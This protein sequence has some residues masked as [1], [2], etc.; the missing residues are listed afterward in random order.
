LSALTGNPIEV[1]GDGS[2]IRSWCYISDFCDAMVEMI[3]RPAAVGQDFNI[4]NPANTVTIL[5][6]AQQILQITNSRVPI[7]FCDH[8]FP[9]IEIRVPSLTKAH[10]I[11]D[12]K[13]VYDLAMALPPTLDWYQENLPFF[14]PQLAAAAKA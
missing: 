6:L 4:G 8:P 10:A 7:K 14:E 9:D 13:P 11:L 2:Q 3:A 5:Q 1:H 12:Y